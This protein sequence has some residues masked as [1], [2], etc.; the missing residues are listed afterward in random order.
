MRAY[1]AQALAT[2]ANLF[3]IPFRRL[4]RLILIISAPRIQRR[5]GPHEITSRFVTNRRKISTTAARPALYQPDRR[6]ENSV[7]RTQNLAERL[8]WAF[9]DEYV[10]R[11]IKKPVIARADVSVTTIR[12]LGLDIDPDGKPHPR[13][14]NIIGWPAAKGAW[15]SHAQ[16][17][18]AAAS[19]HTRP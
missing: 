5:V 7:F 2:G 19:L 3:Q 1:L 13:H 17:L 18:A 16:R 6:L 12:G 8:V 11:K 15:K 4:S 9:A 14:A 10:A